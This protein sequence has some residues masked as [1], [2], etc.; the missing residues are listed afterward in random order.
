M[1][2][3]TRGELERE[4]TKYQQ[5]A[6]QCGPAGDW[7]PFCD[8]YTEHAVMVV[9][10][11]IRVGGREA[12]KRW[13]RDAFSVEPM[14]YLWY[15][16]VEWYMIDEDRGWVSCQFWNR[17]AD[18]GDGSLHQ[19]SNITI[20]K[21]AG[22]G[23]WSYEEDVY[24]PADFAP[25]GEAEM[26]AT[27]DATATTGSWF[28]VSRGPQHATGRNSNRMIVD[29]IEV[30]FEHDPASGQTRLSF[31]KNGNEMS[32]TAF[33]WIDR[34][35]VRLVKSV[36]VDDQ[37]IRFSDGFFTADHQRVLQADPMSALFGAPVAR[38]GYTTGLPLALADH[39]T[40]TVAGD[41]VEHESEVA[42]FALTNAVSFTVG[43]LPAIVG[44]SAA[45]PTTSIAQWKDGDRLITVEG[46]IDPARMVATASAVHASRSDAVH[47][48][49]AE[50]SPASL[51]PRQAGEK[52]VVSG[53]LA[54]GVPWV[55]QVDRR[56]DDPTD[57][58]YTWWIGQPDGT[59][60][61]WQT[62]PRGPDDGPTIDTFVEH[63]RTYVLA[64]IPRSMDG[65]E[66]HVAPTGLPSIVTR[67]HD[68]DATLPGEFAASVFLQPVPFTARIIDANG[69]TVAFWPTFGRAAS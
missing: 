49:L 68:V 16:P 46:N 40:V 60:E 64:S 24:N 10:G 52:T 63:G 3:W 22:D 31:T 33:G 54:D 29:G 65:A 30:V 25:K 15:Y 38:V 55:I 20:L 5:V 66:L 14:K 50:Q 61:P 59:R 45:D 62:R 42:K 11:G 21:Y 44:L 12:M 8:M 9:S 34:Q 2:R 69:T 41:N 56:T 36:N 35:L 27:P 23:L 43:D 4:W 1:G 7:D 18:P 37:S 17:M 57:S 32:I 48:Q 39:F 51:D 67:L 6:L 28:V 47:R 13:Y 58:G 53:M 26:W 19:A